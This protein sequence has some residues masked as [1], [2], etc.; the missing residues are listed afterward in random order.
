MI[1]SM[2][3]LPPDYVI[4]SGGA[5]AFS[6]MRDGM[7]DEAALMDKVAGVGQAI[8]EIVGEAAASGT[9]PLTAARKRVERILAEHRTL[10]P[11]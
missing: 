11:A 5:M 4:N 1:L 9:S 2:Q 10:Q 6:L 3:Y 8:A 7:R